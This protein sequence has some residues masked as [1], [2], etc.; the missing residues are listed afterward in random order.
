MAQHPRFALIPVALALTAGAG[1]ATVGCAGAG[2]QAEMPGDASG[3]PPWDAYQRELFDDNID[4]AAVGLTMDGPS[5]R[6][7]RYLRERAQTSDVVAR[8]RV[9]T[10]TVDSVG[11]AST[12]HLAIQIGYPTLTTARV[13]DRTFELNIRPSSRASGIAKAFDARLRGL[14][15]IGFIR[16]FAGE[17]GE[18]EIHWHLAPDTAEVAAAVKEAVALGELSAP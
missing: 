13:P 10:V 14:T 15:F 4:P 9:N 16:R 11:D 7:D 1:L 8:I 17:A 3:L 18:P 5:P 12:Y 2:E 6:A